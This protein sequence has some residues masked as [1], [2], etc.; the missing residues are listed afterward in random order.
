MP[1]RTVVSEANQND[2]LVVQAR[3][4]STRP[5]RR[6]DQREPEPHG[7]PARPAGCRRRAGRSRGRRGSSP[8]ASARAGSARGAARS[9]RGDRAG[10]SDPGEGAGSI[11]WTCLSLCWGSSADSNHASITSHRRHT[12][13]PTRRHPS[14]R[15]SVGVCRHVRRLAS[16]DGRSPAAA[17]RRARVRLARRRPGADARAPP[18]A[19][20]RRPGPTRPGDAD[21]PAPGASGATAPAAAPASHG[22]R[23]PRAPP[24]PVHRRAPDAAPRS[25]GRSGRRGSGSATAGSCSLLWL[26]FLIAV[27]FFAW[28]KIDKSTRSRA[29][30]GR[31]TSPARRT[32]WS[33]ATAA[34]T[35]PR[36][37]ASSSAPATPRGQRTDT[38]M[39]LHAGS[40]PNLLLS[41]PRDSLVDD[42]GARH[43]QDQ[44]RLRVRRA[45]AAGQDDRAEH[46]HPRS[47]TTSR[48]ASAAS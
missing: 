15:R 34:R 46:R 5:A 9:P 7:D 33:A 14:P 3:P 1:S 35:S 10:P 30:T 8:S 4:T 19:D 21:D 47:T 39:L 38:I 18:A 32:C 20:A 22:G 42:P 41:I 12:A 31:P 6:R 11:A 2:V 17:G 27:P 43:D 48:S 44:R 13:V 45:E 23:R 37:S 36:S 26:V 29:A 25:G 16:P 24:P 40:G 28:S